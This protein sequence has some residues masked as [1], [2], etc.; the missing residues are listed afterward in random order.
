[1]YK[2]MYMIIRN[3]FTKKPQALLTCQSATVAYL[4]I[5]SLAQ[6]PINDRHTKN[7]VRDNS[8]NSE[9]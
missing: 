1:M 7:Y 4:Q 9:L 2:Y 5:A 3:N 8:V 6:Y